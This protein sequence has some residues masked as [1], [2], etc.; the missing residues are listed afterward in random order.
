MFK[1]VDVIIKNSC[2]RLNKK[3]QLNSTLNYQLSSLTTQNEFIPT[4]FDINKKL[5]S[6]HQYNDVISVCIL[7]CADLLCN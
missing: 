4:V 2:Y 1:R 3:T 7:S 6:F 5:R